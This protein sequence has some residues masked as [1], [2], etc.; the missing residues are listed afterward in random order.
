MKPEEIKETL[1]LLNFKWLPKH[2]NHI[3]ESIVFKKRNI[4]FLSIN[5][6]FRQ[7]EYKINQCEQPFKDSYIISGFVPLQSND[8]L[9]TK[10]E[11]LFVIFR[12]DNYKNIIVITA[13]SENDEY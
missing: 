1:K 12:I 7:K 2:L 11:I 3:T 8:K 9:R 5:A 10:E 13:F 4:S 6:L